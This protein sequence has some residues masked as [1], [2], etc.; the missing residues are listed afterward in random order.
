VTIDGYKQSSGTPLNTSQPNN[1]P[2]IDNAVLGV[3][4]TTSFFRSVRDGLQ[5]VGA[6]NVTIKGL[7]IYNFHDDQITIDALPQW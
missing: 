7:A 2:D 6:S 4:I 5:I 1:R 3:A